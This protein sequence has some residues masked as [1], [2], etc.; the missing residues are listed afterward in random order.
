M[1][2]P[3]A[4]GHSKSPKK[5]ISKIFRTKSISTVDTADAAS[6][7]EPL[8]GE[9]LESVKATSA[10]ER[11]TFV[12]L[13]ERAQTMDPEEFRAYLREHQK[14]ENEKYR[15]MGGGPRRG[16]IKNMGQSEAACLRLDEQLQNVLITKQLSTLIYSPSSGAI[17]MRT[18]TKLLKL[19]TCTK[20]SSMLGIFLIGDFNSLIRVD[21]HWASPLMSICLQQAHFI[22]GRIHIFDLSVH[23]SAKFVN[24][25]G[26]FLQAPRRLP[27]I[28]SMALPRD[29]VRTL[30]LEE[31][32]SN[33]GEHGRN[34]VTIKTNYV[35]LPPQALMILFGKLPG[36]TYDSIRPHLN[37]L[38][39]YFNVEEFS[40]TGM[41][42]AQR[43]LH[44]FL[45]SIFA[46]NRLLA[47]IARRDAIP[48][49]QDPG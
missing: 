6:M 43:Q 3:L 11:Q 12:S 21:G 7:I 2:G 15:H 26:I 27:S 1:S 46:Y 37:F 16:Y 40:G 5:W 33:L 36:E 35:S 42:E 9:A 39:E 44:I 24:I 10:D 23:P 4:L 48:A 32:S 47:S 19:S 28:S 41:N 18:K 34:E 8:V 31:S 29:L 30:I 49:I 38:Q 14:K 20:S 17:S 22:H 13:M 25:N 45:R